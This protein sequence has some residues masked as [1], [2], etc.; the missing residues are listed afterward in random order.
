MKATTIASE[1][2]RVRDETADS[3]VSR[4]AGVVTYTSSA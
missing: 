1:R 2:N 3:P 4:A